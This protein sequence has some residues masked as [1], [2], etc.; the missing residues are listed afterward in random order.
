MEVKN[1]IYG[2]PS[3][4]SK[5][6]CNWK[7]IG[8][9]H[10]NFD[11]LFEEYVAITACQ[12]CHKPFKSTKDRCVDHDHD[13]GQMRL[14]VCQKCNNK[15]SYINW[16]DGY[17]VKERTAKYYK[18]NKEKIAEQSAEY[19]Q[20]NKEKLA[21]QKAEYYQQNKEKIAERASEKIKCECGDVVTRA[22][23]S[24]HR[25]TQKHQTNI[26]SLGSANL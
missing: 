10:D 6:I 12:Y 16:P 3:Y 15:D 26:K 19:R 20:K 18:K 9:I 5:M 24:K 8:I 1:K 21:E 14:I 25:K 4:K 7:R 11:T 23:V 2:T 13:T 17:D 22:G